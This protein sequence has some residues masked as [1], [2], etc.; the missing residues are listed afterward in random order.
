[1]SA[2]WKFID[3]KT[4]MI[5]NEEPLRGLLFYYIRRSMNLQDPNDDSQNLEDVPAVTQILENGFAAFH[6]G[7]GQTRWAIG[8]HRQPFSH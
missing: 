8:L 7:R 4:S 6:W 3:Y 2:Y 1:M 5:T